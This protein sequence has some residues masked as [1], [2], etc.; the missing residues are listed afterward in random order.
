MIF[1]IY[2][3]QLF[4]MLTKHLKK[5]IL[6]QTD[7]KPCDIWEEKL[8][9]RGWKREGTPPKASFQKREEAKAF[10]PCNMQLTIRKLGVNCAGT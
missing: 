6:T 8:R 3:L 9:G 7:L 4:C 1:T 10:L 5:F 2:N